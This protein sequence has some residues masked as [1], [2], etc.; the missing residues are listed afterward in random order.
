MIILHIL[1]KY[2]MRGEVQVNS[3]LS[4]SLSPRG[5]DG[6][7]IH[8]PKINCLSLGMKTRGATGVCLKYQLA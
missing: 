7:E 6:A 4:I 1:Y 2:M 3:E 5:G 8:Y